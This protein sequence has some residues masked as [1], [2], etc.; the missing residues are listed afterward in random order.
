MIKKTG[1][2]HKFC[3]SI[4]TVLHIKRGVKYYWSVKAK[5]G[6]VSLNVMSLGNQHDIKTCLN[7]LKCQETDIIFLEH[8]LRF[9]LLTGDGPLS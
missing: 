4:V 5:S 6:K 8:N 3:K 2:V 1:H 7:I 9:M